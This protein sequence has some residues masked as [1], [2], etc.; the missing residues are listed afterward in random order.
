MAEPIRNI[1]KTF[2]IVT[3]PVAFGNIYS[4]YVSFFLFLLL[5]MY[6]YV[7]KGEYK[8]IFE[9][10]IIYFASKLNLHL[11]AKYVLKKGTSETVKL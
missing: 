11:K 10:G 9:Q 2:R 1:C 3:V 8:C 6:V 5:C 7:D 4:M